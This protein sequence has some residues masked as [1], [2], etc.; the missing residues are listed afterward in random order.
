MKK[1]YSYI[2]FSSPEQARGDS[3]RRQTEGAENWCA[4]RGIEL[5]DTLRDLGVSA[6]RGMNRVEGALR[7]F[8]D[9]VEKGDIEEGSYLIVESLDRLSREAVIDAAPRFFD[10]IRA[11]VIVVTLSD[12]QE[13]SSDRLR[14]DWTPLIVSLAVMARAHEESRLKGERVGKAWRRKREEARNE[15][16]PLTPRCPEWLELRDGKF[17]KRRERVDLVHR[18]FRETI[19]GLGR[20]EIVRRLNAESVPTFRGGNGWQTSSIA[21][22]VQN[23]AVLGEYQPHTGTHRAR[24]RRPEGEPILDFYP[25]IIDDETY[26]RAQAALGS[27]RQQ[28]GGRRGNKGAHI[29]QGLAKCA[30]CGGSMHVVDKGPPPKGGVYLS[31]SSYRRNAGCGNSRTWRVDR[32]ERAVLTTV[33]A[34]DAQAFSKVDDT[35]TKAAHKIAALKAEVEDLETRRGHLISLAETGDEAAVGRFRSLIE[36]LQ[37]KQIELGKAENEAAA[38]AA[39]PSVIAR[40]TDAI[41]LS[42]QL[43]NANGEEKRSIRIRLSSILRK[44]IDRIDCD[45]ILGAVAALPQRDYWQ[46]NS[47][48]AYA[49]RADPTGVYILLEENPDDK[50]LDQFFVG[51]G[52]ASGL[53]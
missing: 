25:R 13:Y 14:N 1:A 23:R 46:V 8:L 4:E 51:M 38:F 49:W 19:E 10:L 41:A 39:S 16:R 47:N 22:I 17:H 43:A 20:R 31:C 40:L 9:L 42:A 45:P 28:T 6:Y 2:R 35:T 37:S 53:N 29:L 44:L 11:G 24:N 21:K 15:K 3:L 48:I 36:Q 33:G 50:Q 27:R 18:V 26:W 5:D 32:L 34:L 7:S 52:G 30:A 12:Q